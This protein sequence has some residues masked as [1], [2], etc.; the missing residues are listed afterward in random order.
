MPLLKISNTTARN[1]P[2][3]PNIG[4]NRDVSSPTVRMPSPKTV[5]NKEKASEEWAGNHKEERNYKVYKA[6]SESYL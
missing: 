1:L 6:A 4:C 5:S 3:K 2:K